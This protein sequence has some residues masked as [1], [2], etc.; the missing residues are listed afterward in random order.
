ML[1]VLNILNEDIYTRCSVL[2]PPV[3]KYA[4]IKPSLYLFLLFVIAL[5]PGL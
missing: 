1:I 2:Q 5:K 4:L 3:I